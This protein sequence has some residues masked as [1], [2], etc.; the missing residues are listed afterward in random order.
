MWL[1]SPARPLPP[2]HR[3]SGTSCRPAWAD[4]LGTGTAAFLGARRPAVRLVPGNRV[5]RHP[6]GGLRSFGGS[7]QKRALAARACVCA[8]APP[9]GPR[10][11]VLAARA[12][13]RGPF[14]AAAG[15][16]G[17][18]DAERPAAWPL[19]PTVSADG[20]LGTCHAHDPGPPRSPGAGGDGGARRW[21]HPQQRRSAAGHPT[22]L[23]RDSPAVAP[24]RSGAPRS[25]R[26]EPTQTARGY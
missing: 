10:G 24:L 22:S 7:G 5:R 25:Q 19:C 21:L 2:Q 16:S 8:W 17:K 1:W 12:R 9:A 4:G 20:L 13:P 23:P 6:Q 18:G 15:W 3:H 11:H 14:C 26:T